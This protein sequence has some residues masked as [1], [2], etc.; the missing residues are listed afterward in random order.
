MARTKKKKIR[1]DDTVRMAKEAGM[2]YSEYQVMETMQRIKEQKAGGN[3]GRKE[4]FT[5]AKS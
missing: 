4:N 3:G 1:L 2:T 5:K